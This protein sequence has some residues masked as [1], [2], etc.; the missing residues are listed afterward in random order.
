MKIKCFFKK[1]SGLENF[2]AAKS[3]VDEV[4]ITKPINIRL[5][6]Q[7][8]KRESKPLLSKKSIIFLIFLANILV[9][10]FLEVIS[11]LL[12]VIIH[13]I[14]RCSWR[15]KNSVSWRHNREI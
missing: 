15:H 12:V 9:Y 8:K 7:A 5:V 3:M 6:T 4:T 1:K 14:T 11:S 10:K 2:V 13:T